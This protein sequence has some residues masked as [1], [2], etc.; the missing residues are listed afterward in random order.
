VS[1]WTQDE[2]GTWFFQ[3]AN[4]SVWICARPAYCDRGHWIANVEGIG[5]IDWADAFPR[6]F[7]DLDRAKLEM[8]E[9]LAWRLLTE[10]PA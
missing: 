10:R 7:M 9:W 1:E 6:Y 4:A 2:H 3:I 8:S 5:S